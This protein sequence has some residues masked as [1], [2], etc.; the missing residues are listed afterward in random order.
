MEA[1]FTRAA[2]VAVVLLVSMGAKY[3]SANF[4]IDTP[5][6]RL[7]QRFGEA[8]ES[9]RKTLALSWLGEELA[10]WARPCPV[11]VQ[12]GPHLGAGGATTF[13]FDHGEVFGWNMSIQGSAQRVV[14]SVLPHEITHM[15]FASHFRR[16]LPR[17]A[18]EG[19]ATS[20]EHMSERNK[21]RQMLD[22][23]LRTGRGIAFNKMFAMTEYPSDILPLY[24]Q[25][26]STA[27]YLIQTG[28]RRKY[29]VFLDDGLPGGN[30]SA[31]LKKNYGIGSLG[32]LQ[33][34]WL[35]WVKQGS[36]LKM[37]QPAPAAGATP[38]MLAATGRR[39]PSD[40]TVLPR[41][42]LAPVG[43]APAPDAAAPNHVIAGA[44][45][46]SKSS[47]DAPYTPGSTIAVS[48]FS[49]PSTRWRSAAVDSP[50]SSALATTARASSAAADPY[51]AT[52]GGS[53][54][55]DAPTRTTMWR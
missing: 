4:V 42:P 36:P 14:D 25:G 27:E 29:V 38:D 53:Q 40:P 37:V 3:R 16:P 18:D 21:Q 1:R 15:I 9:Y 8:A 51:R 45:V 35:A 52:A 2:L 54:Q 11:N 5:D 49:V 44:T 48:R 55:I 50:L 12:V 30:W 20:V 47:L 31:A 34:T 26:Y 39:S 41:R 28:G 7:A 19:G 33:M 6:A 13:T 10:N 32:E 22:Q 23:F 46:A 24:A 43:R 17:W